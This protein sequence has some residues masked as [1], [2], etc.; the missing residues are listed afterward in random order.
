VRIEEVRIY[1]EVL[2]QSLDF[3]NYIRKSGFEGAVRTVYA[4][5]T[6][7]AFSPGD[8]LVDRI[9]KVK[10]VDVLITA[11]SAGAEHPI[12]MIEYSTAVPTDD[13]KMQRSD[14]YF[15]SAVFQV[16]V[17]KISPSAKGMDQQFG[18]GSRLTDEQEQRLAFD[19]GALLY[20]I[21][22]N[23]AEGSSVLPVKE[24]MLSCIPYSSGIQ[25]VFD[26]VLSAYMQT[27]DPAL[28][29][30]R[31]KREYLA[32][33]AETLS[34]VSAE[35]IRRSIVNSTRFHWFGDRLSVKIN[36][37]GHAMDPDRGVLYFAN[38][39][40]GAENTIVEIQVNRPD[41]LNCRGG[42]HA[43]F[44]ALPGKTELL[45]YVTELIRDKG[46]RFSDEDAIHVFLYS[47]SIE[48]KLRF[49]RTGSHAYAVCDEVLSAFLRS[50]AGIAAKSIFFLST[51]LRLT[52]KDRNIICTVRWNPAPIRDYLSDVRTNH[53]AP[54]PISP[55]TMR[56]AKEDIVTFASVKL[57]Q[58]LHY[59]LV[60]VSYPGAQ[61][62]RCI[63]TGDGRRVRRTYVD[64][65]AC[66]E[67]EDG[68]RVFLEECKE[69]FSGSGPDVRKLNR[70]IRSEEER[71]GLRALLRKTGKRD[72][73]QE[74]YISIAAKEA[75]MIPQFSVDYLFMFRLS[76]DSEKT[77]IDYTVAI[78]NTDLVKAFQP[79]S[80]G[81]R[82][83][84]RLTFD[85]I[86]SIS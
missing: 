53:R 30:Q 42:Y 29:L 74:L 79:L 54:L 55:L 80:D 72:D 26:S 39:L 56:E 86:Y 63:L 59:E 6:R 34:T 38:M 84:G 50:N 45:R 60:A 46:N 18:G 13:H 75:P 28:F 10:D 32:A 31:L 33:Y 77:Y 49:V 64:I 76:H 5:K 71:E 82:M 47:L 4:K 8:S 67:G 19:R 81:G 24:N 66:R 14:V 40:V 65:I 11:I 15:W 25:S 37:F 51:E 41:D 52:D 23:N 78:V 44:D 85:K 17:M 57:Y 35:T 20:L 68:L 1:A 3:R 21:P 36:R 61:G 70:L 22:W 7:E 69:Q 16:P 43:L 12:L 73:I 62:D 48:D 27:Q 58:K 2:E 9:R 83:V